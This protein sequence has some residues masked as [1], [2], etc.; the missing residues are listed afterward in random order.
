[1]SP[2]EVAPRRRGGGDGREMLWSRDVIGTR[3][4]HAGR[5]AWARGGCPSNMTT[6]SLEECVSLVADV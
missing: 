5:R 1:M 4:Q 6:R 2:A 3:L